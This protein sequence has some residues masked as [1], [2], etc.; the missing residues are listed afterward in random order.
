[1]TSTKTIGVLGGM[2]PMATVDFFRR[3]VTAT[4]AENDQAH[5]HILIDND[6]HIPDRTAAILHGGPS[7]VAALRGMARRLEDAGADLLAMPC[8]TAHAYL[9][10]IRASVSIPVLDMIGETVG[11]LDRSPTGLLSTDGT[12]RA[13]LYQR[14]CEARGIRIVVPDPADQRTVTEAISRIKRGEDPRRVGESLRPVVRGLQRDGAKSVIAA[15]TEIS[16]VPADGLTIPWIDAL[17]RLVEA[18]LRD[19]GA[20]GE[21]WNGKEA[22]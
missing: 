16:L 3:L 2:G 13:G 5:L 15:C 11:T 12:V 9:D 22:E 19:A 17:D 1:M 8:N 18:T 10:E 7:P 14:A 6:P 21:T 20:K 4:S